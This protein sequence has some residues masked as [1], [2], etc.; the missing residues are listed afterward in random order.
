M[1]KEALKSANGNTKTEFSPEE[2]KISQVRTSSQRW[3]IAHLLAGPNKF[4]IVIIFF[5]TILSS[6]LGS[7]LMVLIGT[8]I[9]EFSVGDS[10]NLSSYAVFFFVFAVGSP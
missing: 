6:L 10:S 1:Q 2:D 7:G 9:D 3:I 4:I 8:A 5:G